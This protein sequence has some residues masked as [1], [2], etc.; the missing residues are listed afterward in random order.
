MKEYIIAD[1]FLDGL[2]K[3]FASAQGQLKELIRCKDCKYWP[4]KAITYASADPYLE[5]YP[6]CFHQDG[7]WYCGDAEKEEE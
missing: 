4:Y 7:N 6:H 1:D 3:K 5:S 2:T